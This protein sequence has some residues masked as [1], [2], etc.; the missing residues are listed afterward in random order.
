MILHIQYSTWHRAGKWIKEKYTYFIYTKV[1]GLYVS[2][3][4]TLQPINMNHLKVETSSS[5]QWSSKEV[6]W[7]R[8][9]LPKWK[10]ISNLIT[11]SRVYYVEFIWLMLW[12]K[13]SSPIKNKKHLKNNFIWTNMF[14]KRQSLIILCNKNLV[15]QI[16][17]KEKNSNS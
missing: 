2:T 6:I 3:K 10:S 17:R 13:G 1:T 9:P 14:L 5:F 16:H 7:N 12:Q 8:F 15:N 4:Y 11:L